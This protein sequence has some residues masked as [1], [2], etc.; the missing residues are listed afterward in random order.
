MADELVFDA[1]PLIAYYW[2]ERG[3][4][5]VDRQLERLEEGT[6]RGAISTV[7]CTEVR[8]VVDRDDPDR[9]AAYVDRLRNWLTVV[10]AERVW[11]RAAR[12]KLEHAVALGDAYTLATAAE[13]GATAF[14]GADAEYDGIEAVEIERFRS[15]GVGP[16]PDNR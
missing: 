14:V 6:V 12:F 11:D 9:A 5:A 2:D 4:D 7:T 15:H 13:L 3:A 10:D 16:G 1:E 8:Y